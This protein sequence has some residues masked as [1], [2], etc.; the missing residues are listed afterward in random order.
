MRTTYLMIP[1]FWACEMDKA[2]M[3][4]TGEFMG[5]GDAEQNEEENEEQSEEQASD[6]CASAAT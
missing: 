3:A 6:P 4:V 5:S 1:V 2:T